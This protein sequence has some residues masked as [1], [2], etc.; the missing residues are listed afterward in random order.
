[1][2]KALRSAQMAVE[3]VENID[4]LFGLAISYV[5]PGLLALFGLSYQVAELR[6]WFGFVAAHETNIAGFLF[7]LVASVGVGV[8]LSAIRAILLEK[9]TSLARPKTGDMSGRAQVETTYRAL[10]SDHYCYYKAYG[11][12]AVAILILSVCY[13][14][15]A[16]HGA[17]AWT[18]WLASTAVFDA[19]LI[20][21][22]VDA[23][24]RFEA[25]RGSLLGWKTG[26]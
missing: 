17:W 9:I 20:W 21:A 19:L 5:I 22:A 18:G 3:R 23:I 6:A 16:H 15:S 10:I 26:A 7:V 2:E 8:M 4:R 12:G 1:M 14:S 25:K 11:N 24:Q 13:F